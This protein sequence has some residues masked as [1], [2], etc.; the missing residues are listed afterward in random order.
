VS[1][2]ASSRTARI[3]TACSSSGTPSAARARTRSTTARACPSGS[4]A[5]QKAG[6]GKS[7]YRGFSAPGGIFE[8]PAAPGNPVP[9]IK[10]AD[11][12]DGISNTLLVVDAGEAVEWTKPDDLDF[13]LGRPRP[14]FGGA[15]PNLP[16][17]LVLMAD[18]TVQ[19]MRKDVP[20]DTLRKLIDRKDG[21]VIPAGWQGQ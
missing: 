7:F 16:F 20:D 17:V 21:G 12:T 18:G 4:G 13:A 10:T 11:I 15:Y 8:K 3:R 6:A 14:A 5:R 19:Q 1:G 2:R 9:K